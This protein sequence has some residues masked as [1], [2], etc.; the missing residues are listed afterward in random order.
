MAIVKPCSKCDGEG[1]MECPTCEHLH[2]QRNPWPRLFCMLC[3]GTNDAP[4]D[5][6]GG[7]GYEVYSV[8]QVIHDSETET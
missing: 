4:C 3:S 6:C 8:Q 5:V 1:I 7:S 2:N